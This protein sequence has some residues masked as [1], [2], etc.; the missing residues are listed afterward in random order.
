MTITFVDKILNEPCNHEWYTEHN[1]WVGI[2]Y[3]CMYCNERK[4]IKNKVRTMNC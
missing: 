4:Y 1:N 3:I 2:G